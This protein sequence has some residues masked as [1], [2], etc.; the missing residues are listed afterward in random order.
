MQDVETRGLEVIREVVRLD[1]PGQGQHRQP[2]HQGDVDRHR[3]RRPPVAALRDHHQR[4]TDYE[5]Q[6][7]C[8]AL[9]RI[10]LTI[11]HATTS[12]CTINRRREPPCTVSFPSSGCRTAQWTGP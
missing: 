4:D 9:A 12:P 8:R 2:Q 5:K 10:E 11:R 7:R 3:H 1:A 6:Q